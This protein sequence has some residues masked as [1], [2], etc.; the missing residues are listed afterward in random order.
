M[1]GRAALALMLL[2]AGNAWAEQVT[3]PAEAQGASSPPASVANSRHN[4]QRNPLSGDCADPVSEKFAGKPGI[5]LA[6][7]TP[8]WSCS[9]ARN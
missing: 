1:L 3:A 2:V 5:G 6:E 8:I 4:I 7:A 9:D